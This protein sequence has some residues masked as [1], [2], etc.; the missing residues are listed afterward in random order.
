MNTKDAILGA[1]ERMVR[2]GGYAAF[3][4]REIATEV[5][6]KSSSVH[7]YFPTKEDLGAAL[8]KSYTEGFLNL[9]GDP[10]ELM[11][12]GKD[13]ITLYANS[14]KEALQKDKKMCLCGQLGAEV[15]VL[16]PKVVTETQAFFEQNID[17]LT[18]AYKAKNDAHPAQSA[19]RTLALLE[20]AMMISVALNDPTRLDEIAKIL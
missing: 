8:A 2:H 16:P 1:A 19:L 3:S 17:W 11:G 5:G 18:R 4:F 6:I 13:P 10:I 20:G 9:L 15:S 7:Y 12:S 14:F